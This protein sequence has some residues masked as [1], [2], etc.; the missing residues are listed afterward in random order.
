MLPNESYC[1]VNRIIL[2]T[3]SPHEP[4]PNCPWTMSLC[5]S[6][7]PVNHVK[8]CH[9]RY[10]CVNHVVT[11]TIV[12]SELYYPINY[13]LHTGQYCRKDRVVPWITLS[14]ESCCPVKYIIQMNETAPW[15]KSPHVPWYTVKFITPHEPYVWWTIYYLLNYISPWAVLPYNH[16]APETVLLYEPS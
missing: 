8:P 13:T 14:C 2:W 10:R 4:G 5:R 3:I 15:T 11:W 12:R 9:E 6:H 1:A 7:C 16:I